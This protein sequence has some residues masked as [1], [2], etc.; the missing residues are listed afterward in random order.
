MCVNGTHPWKRKMSLPTGRLLRDRSNN[1]CTGSGR[2]LRGQAAFVGKFEIPV[3][4]TVSPHWR[5]G[6]EGQVQDDTRH[7]D[8]VLAV[9]FLGITPQG[10]LPNEIATYKTCVGLFDIATKFPSLRT[11]HRLRA[12]VTWQGTPL[13]RTPFVS[14]WSWGLP[15]C[16]TLRKKLVRVGLC[17]GTSLVCD[18]ARDTASDGRRA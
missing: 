9:H 11:R 12:C 5:K 17:E 1:R 18:L 14:A 2:Q 16:R 7:V 13:E 4:R 8:T 3:D 6:T 15:S 10:F